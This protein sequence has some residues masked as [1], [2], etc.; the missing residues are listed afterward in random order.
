MHVYFDINEDTMLRLVKSGSI[1]TQGEGS[2]YA[3]Q[4]GLADEDDFPHSGTI[5]FSDNKLDAA[6]G[7]LR[8]RGLLP[9][10]KPRLISPGMFARVRLPVSD[11]HDVL[12]VPK[13]AV[14][15]D[16]GRKYVYVITPQ[17]EID[18]RPIRVGAPHKGLVVVE[19]GLNPGERVVVVGQQAVRHGIKVTPSDVAAR[20]TAGAAPKRAGRPKVAAATKKA[21]PVVLFTTPREDSVRE[22]EDF[23]GHV[24]SVKSVEIRARVTGHLSQV[25]FKDGDEVKE[26]AQLFEI[27]PRPYQA[28]YDRSVATLHQAEARERRLSQDHRRA[29][30]NYQNGAISREEFDK[31]AGDLAEA[32]ATV[33]MAKAARD[34]A[35]LNLGFTKVFAP[36]GG[37]LSRRLV[38]PG[39]LVQADVTPL[40]TIVTLDP[41]YVYF[42]VDERTMLRLRRLIKEGRIKPR[43]E[44]GQYTIQTGLADEPDFPRT[45][46]INFSDNKVDVATGTLQV[47]G[48]IANPTPRVLSPGMFARVRLPIGE[49][50]KALMVPEQAVGTD[51]GSKYVFV[52]TPDNKIERRPITVGVLRDSLRAVLSGLSAAERIVVIGQQRIRPGDEVVAKAWIDARSKESSKPGSVSPAKKSATPAVAGERDAE[53]KRTSSSD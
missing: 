19:S 1:K 5:N 32:E 52:I 35:E 46:E 9:N 2:V 8:V 28:E 13:E 16:Q 37:R 40:T 50:R 23:T 18:Y 30:S 12:L 33:A 26:G 29:Q 17:D 21:I 36:V 7:T 6:T 44:G 24:E 11:P 25:F 15:T 47:R 38:D 45:G 39:N 49:A 48:A 27:D 53:P 20:S 43:D 34:L 31:I 41:M 10:A 22:Y 42:D 14:G 3:I 51:Q 4:V